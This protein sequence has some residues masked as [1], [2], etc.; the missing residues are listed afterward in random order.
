[1]AIPRDLDDAYEALVELVGRIS[2]AE[3]APETLG[4]TVDEWRAADCRGAA[5]L[6]GAAIRTLQYELATLGLSGG[7][8]ESVADL[9]SLKQVQTILEE[10]ERTGADA[11][12]NEQAEIVEVALP[13]D[14]WTTMQ[15][16]R[17]FRIGELQVI[18]EP[19]EGP[20]HGHLSVSHPYRY[21]TFDELLRAAQAPGGPPPNL[22]AWVPKPAQHENMQP[23]IVHLYVLP[24]E[25]LLG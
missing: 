16:G 18:F 3:V 15:N 5:T 22:W 20:P 8:E 4:E 24:P 23:N 19:S 21:P 10:P 9:K 6:A 14:L 13:E 1:M 11:E 25:G 2:R 17:G 12:A 7:M